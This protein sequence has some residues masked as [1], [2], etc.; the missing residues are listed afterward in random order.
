MILAVGLMF[1]LIRVGR[2]GRAWNK[3]HAYTFITSDQDWYSG[4]IIIALELSESLVPQVELELDV[5]CH[6]T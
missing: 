4:D 5:E 6:E 3:G 2:T 1:S